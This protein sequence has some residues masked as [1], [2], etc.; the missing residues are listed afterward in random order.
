[1]NRWALLL[2]LCVALAGCGRG[3]DEIVA[4]SVAHRFLTS[5]SNDNGDVACSLL[6]RETAAALAHDEREPCEETVRGLELNAPSAERVQVF[7]LSAKVDLA[8]GLSVFLELTPEG[9]RVSAAGCEPVAGDQP[10]ECE[11]EA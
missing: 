11:V 2:G 5:V 6:S 3:E 10:Y 8:D 7:G 1:V 9:W 4:S